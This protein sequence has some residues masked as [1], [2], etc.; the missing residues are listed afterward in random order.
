M[1]DELKVLVVDDSASDRLLFRT[2]IE[3][4]VGVMEASQTVEALEYLSCT[5]L[6]GIVVDIRMP[7]QSGI[8]F[9]EELRQRTKSSWPPVVVWSSSQNQK[10]VLNAYQVGA[11]LF[12]QK[13]ES[14]ADMRRA[15]RCCVEFF[16]LGIQPR[17]L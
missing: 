14:F 5:D 15:L 17:S 13:P 2:C 16:T 12:L 3:D 10:D 4:L 8:E 1:S 6:I 9:V 7:G 11:S